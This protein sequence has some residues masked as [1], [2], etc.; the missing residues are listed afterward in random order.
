[1]AINKDE[2][3][4]GSFE[5]LAEGDG[6]KVKRIE[7]EPGH[8]LSLQMH[9]SRSEHWV[10]VA[11][12]AI[13]TVGDKEARLGVNHELFIPARSKHRVANTGDVK[14]VFIE[15]QCGSYLGEDDITRFEDDY[16]RTLPVATN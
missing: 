10:V 15:V 1:M 14:L 16:N 12:E 3:P 11:G 8:R 13:V 2:R 5:V 4:W 6:Y 9:Q 7:V